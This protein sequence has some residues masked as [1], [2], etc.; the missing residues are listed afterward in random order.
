MNAD[1]LQLRA[2]FDRQ[3]AHRWRVAATSPSER[4][5]KLRRLRAAILKRQEELYAAIWN[6][7]R[8]SPFE[9]WLTEVFPSIEEIDVAIKRLAFWMREKRVGGAFVLPL[10]RARLRYEPKGRVLIMSPWNYPFQLLIAPLVSAI[11]AGNCV[12]AKPSNKTARTSAYIAS[13]LGEIFP[14]EEVAVVEGPG[15]TLGECLLKLPFDHVF[16]TG[17]PRVGARV[18]EAAARVHAG[19]T[20]ELGGKSPTIL[21]PGADIDDAAAKIMWGKCLN[22]GQTCIAPD[23]LL[24]PAPAVD[25][26]ACAARKS[27]QTFYGDTEE[28]WRASDQLPRIVDRGSCER[29]ERLVKEAI[30]R[31]AEARFGAHFDPG[32]RYAAPT[33]LT[34]VRPDMEIMGEE[35]FGPILPVITY[36]SIDEVLDFIR[37]RPKPLALYIFAKNRR[38]ARPL[39]TGTTSGSVCINDLI[40]QIENPNLPFGGVGMSGTGS[41]HGFFGF[42]TFSHERNV[43]AQGPLSLASA[44]Y[45][46]YGTRF[47]KRFSGVIR[48]LRGMSGGDH[49]L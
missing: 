13:L 30:D 32:E 7:F 31:G 14:P 4:V 42:R 48:R 24:C 16:F 26:F 27:V 10:A 40:V 1:Q 3:G 23:Y 43:V 46:P 8:K 19:L 28:Q 21:L 6:D 5:A 17:S 29:M 25:S 35:I 9:T 47:Q 12:I 15:G 38:D 36:D 11:A 33:L 20:L 2:I 37:A 44:F 45:P 41:Y 39:V 18:G 34:S 49:T 22:A